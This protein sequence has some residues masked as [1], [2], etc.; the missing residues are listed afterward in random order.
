MADIL[1]IF[2][3]KGSVE[4]IFDAITTPNGLNCWWPLRSEGSPKLKNEYTFYF[5]PE[6]D[7]RAEVIEVSQNKSIT[8]LMT[9]AMEDWM[10]TLVGFK[11]EPKTDHVQVTFFHNNWKDASEH[12][13]ISTFCW[14]QLLN[15]LKNYVEKGVI[16]PHA[17]R[18]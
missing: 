5:G 4:K 12:Y 7:W 1:H 16:I 17:E 6:Y 9:S 3:I 11:L 10:N 8:W 15:G 13:G 2:P 14:G 18:N